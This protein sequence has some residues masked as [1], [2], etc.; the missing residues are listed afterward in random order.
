MQLIMN[1]INSV[2]YYVDE[3]RDVELLQQTT[4]QVGHLLVAHGAQLARDLLDR[5]AIRRQQQQ[6]RQLVVFT[7]ETTQV[8]VTNQL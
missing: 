7:H 6:R 3:R 5:R 8:D 1:Y 4:R 2:T